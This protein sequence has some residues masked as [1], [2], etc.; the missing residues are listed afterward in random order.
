VSL[1]LAL[2][3]YD[4]LPSGVTAT[5]TG[6]LGASV[7]VYYTPA[8]RPWPGDDWILGGTRTGNGDIEIL[9]DKRHYFFVAKVAGDC[10]LPERFAVNDGLDPLATRCRAATIAILKTLALTQIGDEVNDQ[11]FPDASEFKMPCITVYIE[12][13]AERRED[14]TNE[15]DAVGYPIT[16]MVFDT[17]SKTDH[18]KA[19]LYEGWREKISRAFRDQHLGGVPESLYTRVEPVNIA[20]APNDEYSHY[21]GGFNIINFVREPRGQGA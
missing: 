11:I 15:L 21:V 4:D 18:S 14:N 16:V 2:A 20:T 8:D 7:S 10:T 9:L 13:G 17:H 19:A 1:G 3:D 5:L 6:T 12:G